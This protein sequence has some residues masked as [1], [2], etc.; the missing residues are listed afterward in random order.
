MQESRLSYT[1][2][3]EASKIGIFAGSGDLPLQLVE[4]CKQQGR[5]VFV[6]AI[7]EQTSPEVVENVP[8]IWIKLGAIGK[9][10]EALHNAQVKNMVLAG[11][12]GRP[13]LSSLQP[14]LVTAKLLKHLGTKLF[15]SDNS[16]FSA[17]VAFIEQEGFHVLGIDDV[18]RDVVAPEGP[19]GRI[20]P[21][22]QAQADIEA[23]VK[24]AHAI[25]AHDIGQAVI[26]KY[27]LVL[28]VE[29]A[30]GTDALIS[31]CTG[32]AGEGSGGVL[33]KA[34]KPLQERR[35][36]LP[37]IGVRTV[38]NVAA[39]GFD[40]IAIEAGGSIIIDRKAVATRADALGI[41]VIGFSRS[42]S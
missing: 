13:K 25:G 17:I 23:G 1:P 36:D 28:G 12:I 26:I 9:A 16:L 15:S 41:F 29:A 6:V 14:D 30:E 18:L 38:E 22:K 3:Y 35:V 37:T 32:I 39:A 5:D 19:L 24:I 8:H 4:S 10:L 40:G 27:G 33:I 11:R 42:D 2:V 31:R 20:L 21:N 7:E 34:K